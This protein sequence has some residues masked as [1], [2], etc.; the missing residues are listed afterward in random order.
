MCS[1]AVITSLSQDVIATDLWRCTAPLVLKGYIGWHQDVFVDDSLL[2][3]QL[4]THGPRHWIRQDDVAQFSTWL[5]ALAENPR[6][7]WIG[8]VHPSTAH[9][10]IIEHLHFIGMDSVADI[11]VQMMAVGDDWPLSGPRCPVNV[12]LYGTPSTP[13]PT[14]RGNR[15]WCQSYPPV[16]KN[17]DRS[18][19]TTQQ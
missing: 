6:V 13:L 16:H 4:V 19:T 9:W 17:L 8:G 3:H 15:S 1:H 12:I 7:L 18:G 14:D 2:Y 10:A 5:T 11:Y